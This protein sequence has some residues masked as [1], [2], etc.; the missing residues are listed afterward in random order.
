MNHLQTPLGEITVLADGLPVAYTAVQKQN[1]YTSECYRI[2]VPSNGYSEIACVLL[3]QDTDLRGEA[4][5]GEGYLCMEFINES[6]KLSIGMAVDE[7]ATPKYKSEVIENGLAYG[8]I[9]HIEPLIFGI[10]WVC[11]Y[12]ENDVRTWYAADP[13]LD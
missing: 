9:S 13:T 8:D 5:S 12:T 11:D 7:A 10:A 4:S 3:S 2:Y 6:T 1:R